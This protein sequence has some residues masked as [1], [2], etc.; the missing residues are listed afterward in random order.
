MIKKYV[1][2]G[3]GQFYFFLKLVRFEEWKTRKFFQ[4]VSFF[5]TSSDRRHP[6]TIGR[7]YERKEKKIYWFFFSSQ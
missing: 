4:R 7:L 6:H 3:F 5:G 2:Q 1:K